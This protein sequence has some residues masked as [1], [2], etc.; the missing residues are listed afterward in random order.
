[1]GPP[2]TLVSFTEWIRRE[3]HIRQLLK[4]GPDDCAVCGKRM[5]R[6]RGESTHQE[7]GGSPLCRSCFGNVLKMAAK[8]IDFSSESAIAP[9]RT[10]GSRFF[11]RKVS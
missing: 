1:M 11:R 8:A 7:T 2:G 3:L 9:P 4:P 6:L 10:R 5:P